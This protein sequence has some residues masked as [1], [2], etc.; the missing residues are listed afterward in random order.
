MASE[1]MRRL[2][3][4][5]SLFGGSGMHG[6]RLL[7]QILLLAIIVGKSYFVSGKISKGEFFKY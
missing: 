2:R 4:P 3:K 1:F 7:L 6:M 5:C